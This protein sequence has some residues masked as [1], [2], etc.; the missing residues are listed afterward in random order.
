MSLTEPELPEMLSL[1]EAF[2]AAFYMICNSQI[3]SGRRD[4]THHR[5]YADI[6]IMLTLFALPS[7]W[8][9]WWPRWLFLLTP[10]YLVR[11]AFGRLA[12][13]PSPSTLRP[14]ATATGC[15]FPRICRSVR[16]PT[17]DQALC[18]DLE[19]WNELPFADPS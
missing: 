1:D 3:V 8:L 15:T 9:A 17:H 13:A 18:A 5:V 2:R 6:A 7:L 11:V 4:P 19:P 16:V 10:A 14:V 12:L